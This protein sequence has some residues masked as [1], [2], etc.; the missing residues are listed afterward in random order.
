MVNFPNHTIAISQKKLD[1]PNCHFT[2]YIPELITPWHVEKA[3]WELIQ[4]Q[5]KQIEMLRGMILRMQGDHQH[6]F[7]REKDR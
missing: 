5:L 6:G 4:D 2:I 7:D 3:T 1:C